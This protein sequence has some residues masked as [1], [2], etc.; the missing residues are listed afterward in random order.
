MK[1]LLVK[2]LNK[3]AQKPLTAIPFFRT[4]HTLGTFGDK[5]AKLK[6]LSSK[7]NDRFYGFIQI[8]I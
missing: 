7:K 8:S 3:V 6:N 5:E 2:K 1:G 4:F